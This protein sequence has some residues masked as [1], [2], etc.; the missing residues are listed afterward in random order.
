MNSEIKQFNNYNFDLPKIE[1]LK[2]KSENPAEWTYERLKSYIED[3]EKELDNEHQVGIKLV[4]FGNGNAFYV[5]DIG[6]WGPDLMC[7]YCYDKSTESKI[8][9]IQNVSQVNLLLMALPVI[10][11][12]KRKV[13]F[14]VE[15]DSNEN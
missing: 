14:Q 7:F 13:G 12:V 8:Q 11:V 15:K 3:F 1:I 10:K 6:Y 4:S 5:E 2:F 9:L